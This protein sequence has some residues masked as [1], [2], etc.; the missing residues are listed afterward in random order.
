[1]IDRADISLVIPVYNEAA[2]VEALMD[3]ISNQSMPPGV[4]IFVDAGSTD[5]TVQLIQ[6]KEVFGIQYKVVE[7]GRAMPGKAR[8]I[9]VENAYTQWIAFTDAGIQLHKDWL[10]ELVTAADNNK[11]ASIVYGNYEPVT[12]RFFEKCAAIS[13][14]APL[15]Q[16]TI[17]GKFIASSLFKKEVWEKA[18]GFPDWRAAEDL[19]FMEQAEAKGYTAALAPAAIVYWT[20]RPT[21]AATY[22]RFA[23]YSKYNVWAGRQAYWH[24]GMAKQYAIVLS[25]I[26]LGFFHHWLWFLAVPLWLLARTAKRILLHRNEFGWRPL[27]SPPFFLLIMLLTVVID[28][29]TFTGWIKAITNKSALLQPSTE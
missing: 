18:G 9:G 25:F 11:E 4:V 27:F 15:Q 16:N 28:A 5:N 19:I 29:A 6:Q 8:N 3:T 1:M 24:Y 12:T 22:K 14:V 17:R 13:Y 2:S 7:A 20:L 10:K 26:L 23:L 21:L